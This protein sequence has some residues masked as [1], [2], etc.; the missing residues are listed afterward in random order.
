MA[1]GTPLRAA[2]KGDLW[3]LKLGAG[4]HM[5]RFRRG[6]S[7]HIR[8]VPLKKQRQIFA[9][10]AFLTDHRIADTH[11]FASLLHCAAGLAAPVQVAK[12]RCSRP[13]EK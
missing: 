6:I 5:D 2:Q 4:Q 1:S 13:H 7:V 12:R 11:G 8:G 3:P 10:R 9:Q